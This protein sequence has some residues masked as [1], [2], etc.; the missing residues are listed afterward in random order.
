V[1]VTRVRGGER[2]I[3]GAAVAQQFWPA[4]LDGAVSSTHYAL[5]MRIAG[6][7]SSRS[8]LLPTGFF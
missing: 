8:P 1:Q 4:W 7:T 5:E 3:A 2:P 6:F